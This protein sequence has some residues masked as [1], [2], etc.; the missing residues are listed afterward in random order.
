MLSHDRPASLRLLNRELGILA[1]NERVLALSEDASIPLLERLRYL[2]IV[3]NNLDELFEVRV[4]ELKE[5]VRADPLAQ[6]DGLSVADALQAVAERARRMVAR[7]YE[8]LNRTL[9]PALAA[10]GVVMLLSSMWTER[11]RAWAEQVFESEIEPLLTPIALDPAHPFPRILNKSLNFV[12]ELEGTDAFGR[13]AGIAIV[14]APRALPRVIRVPADV[15]GVP[16]G[17]M[18]LTSIVGGF[19]DRLF[20]GLEVRSV[21]QFR[22]TR[23]SELFVDEEEITDL[24]EALHT[25]LTQRHYGDEV[26]LEVSAAIGQSVLQRLM[27]EFDLGAQDCYRVDGPVNLVRLQQVIDLVDRPELKFPSFEPGVPAAIRGRDLFAAIRRSDVL[28]HHPYESFAPVMDFLR[29]AAADPQVVAIKQ[30]IYRTGADSVL[31][32][33]LVA[34]ARAGKEV[35][36]VVELMARFDEEANINWAS[37]LEEAG[38]HVV[39]GVVGHKT[40]AKLALLLRREDGVLRRYAHLG[41]GNYHPNTARLY[42]DFGLFTADPEICADVHEVFRR[43]TGTGRGVDLRCLLQA[44]FTLAAHVLAAIRREAEA[45]RAGR[46]AY[47]A[48]KVNALL[49]PTVIEAL[50]QASQDG[51]K[52]DLIVRGVCA[53]RPGVPGLSETI[54]VRSVIGRFLEHSRIY[55]FHAD[56][57]DEVWLASADWMGRN[58]YRRVEVAFPVRDRRLKARVMSEGISVHLRD[59][60]SAWTMDAE[61]TYTRRRPRGAR[62]IVSQQALLGK[63]A[64]R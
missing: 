17:V 43:L 63:L 25:E 6:L 30:T 57:R 36:V 3:S 62:R 58:L 29:S 38:A 42:E 1:F 7:Q 23:N 22:V 26:R 60:A 13:K 61:G 12:L 45:A 21:N 59:N 49:D 37:R 5:L 52:I 33:S 35:T 27:T 32:E 19:V 39:Y 31:M 18:L 11:Q 51:V 41:T 56:G 50:Y 40:H 55:H 16:H 4:A 46:R 2:T 34:A 44:P 24:R 47:I 53:L 15:A 64:A 48:A 10:E 20:P 54:R 14:Q 8:L 28:L 9:T